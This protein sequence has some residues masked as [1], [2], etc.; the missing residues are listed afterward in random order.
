MIDPP[1]G[2]ESTNGK[3]SWRRYVAEGQ[4][5][6]ARQTP[7]A[8]KGPPHPA[9]WLGGERVSGASVIG[10]PWSLGAQ[11][12]APVRPI[13]ARMI[14]IQAPFAGHVLDEAVAG[15]VVDKFAVQPLARSEERLA[16]VGGIVVPVVASFQIESYAMRANAAVSIEE[17]TQASAKVQFWI[18]VLKE[19][20]RE[21]APFFAKGIA[22]KKASDAELAK[23][24]ADLYPTAPAGTTPLDAMVADILAPLMTMPPPQGSPETAA[25]EE[26]QSADV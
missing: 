18:S 19:S 1:A 15:T 10:Y 14:E 23:I 4:A 22:K 7:E 24:M 20:L 25:S 5:R 9:P 11:V 16:A 13:T 8:T 26:E 17:H 3:R 2:G 21:S 6:E 12:L